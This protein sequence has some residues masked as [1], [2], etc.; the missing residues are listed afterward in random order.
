M[1]AE[2]PFQPSPAA[3]R[4]LHGLLRQGTLLAHWQAGEVLNTMIGE[5]RSAYGQN[6]MDML[7]TAL[8]TLGG[9]AASASNLH[10]SRLLRR[11]WT[12]QDVRAAAKAG[13]TWHDT[14]QLLSLDG[15]ARGLPQ[16]RRQA[17]I[18][19]RQALAHRY[20]RDAAGRKEWN[21]QLTAAKAGCLKHAGAGA[22][23]K[24]IAE[25]RQAIDYRLKAALDRL[26]KS[27][28]LLPGRKRRRQASRLS[29]TL[30]AVRSQVETLYR[31]AAR[32]LKKAK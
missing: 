18:R 27:L 24:Q 6:V 9:V 10:F 15:L 30:T 17:L 8:K 25:A 12:L 26:T 20:R 32:R 11:F 1:P 5:E 7:S 3:L 16:D 29:Q 13:M 28:N 14:V 21:R 4:R 22:R 31:N 23:A 2:A 19:Q